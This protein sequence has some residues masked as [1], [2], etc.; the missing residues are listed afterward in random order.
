MH[1][2]CPGLCK[3][4]LP[5][6]SLYEGTFEN[7]LF[8]GNG[9]IQWRNGNRY[10]G[11]FQNGQMEGQGTLITANGDRYIGGFAAG[12]IEGEGVF[13]YANGAK[14]TGEF[15]GGQFH[16]TGVL[17]QAN[18]D[19]Y[20]GEFQNN[21]Y[22][23]R[24]I[25]T[26]RRPTGNQDRRVGEWA[27][28]R[29]LTPSSPG[30]QQTAHPPLNAEAVLYRQYPLLSH[31]LKEIRPSRPGITD[32]YF[33]SFGSNDRQDV[34][35]NEALF[36]RELF[37]RRF[38]TEHRSMALINHPKMVQ[39]LPLASVVNLKEAL[40]ALSK[41]MDI[42]EDI[43]FLY[44]TGHGQKEG[45]MEVGL[46][47][48]PLQQLSAREL[49]D[50]LKASAIKWKV[51][52]ISACYS[53][54]F[55]DPLKDD[56]TLVMTSARADRTSFGCS[57]DAEMTYFGRAFFQEALDPSVSFPE[58]FEKAKTLVTQWEDEGR[59]E[60]SEPQIHLALP[61]EVKLEQWRATLSEP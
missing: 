11:E 28:G 7:G 3:V 9:S 1:P 55:I 17:V 41:R 19:Q 12:M 58:A 39:Q 30:A 22:H 38:G 36:T 16:G 2:D 43:L 57:D 15:K 50:M 53:G 13:S 4:S 27:Q 20:V 54:S 35:M 34:F 60:H 32:L 5:D 56:H 61:I 6:G 52:V 23:G 48:V 8:H 40:M 37:E 59:F 25:L 21:L 33:V 47:G 45:V 49:A 14:Y 46:S 26:F 44:L 31:S 18:G 10:R 29:F 51:V 42:E 24:G